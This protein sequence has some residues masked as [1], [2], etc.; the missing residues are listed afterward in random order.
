MLVVDDV[1]TA[2]LALWVGVVRQA[3]GR[4]VSVALS[5]GSTP[6]EMFSRLGAPDMVR[7]WPWEQLVLFWGDERPV[8]PDHPDSN[9]GAARERWLDRVPLPARQIHPWPTELA[10]EAAA[11]QYAATLTA[12]MGPEPVFDL[13]WLGVGPEG[14]TASLFPG[15]PA[16]WTTALTAAPY[17]AAKDTVRLT[18]TPRVFNLSRRV[19]F[20]ARGEDK[21]EIVQR[22][23]SEPD[24]EL[25]VQAIQPAADPWWILDRAA[26]AGLPTFPVSESPHPR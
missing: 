22:A 2:A 8:P 20:L 1:T 14:H 10:P 11:R 21:R 9:Y 17:V 16:L 19:V 13:V 3:G 18:L 15:S 12:A 6:L 4:R 24:A 5:G 7:Q 25:P 23:F 26:A